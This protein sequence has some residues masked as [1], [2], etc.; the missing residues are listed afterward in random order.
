MCLPLAA[1]AQKTGQNTRKLIPYD[2]YIDDMPNGLRL[3]TVPTDYPHLVAL[4]IV[5]QTGSRNE[6]E[7]GKSGY[8]H[9]F[10]HLMFRGSKNFTPQ[11]RDEILKRAGASSNANTSDDRTIYHEVFSREDLD[12]VMQ[13]EADRFKDLQYDEA[14]F[15]TEALAILGEYNKSIS[16]PL[17]KLEE[18]VR[19]KA[20]DTH[21]YTHTTLGFLKDIQDMPN[22]YKYSLDFYRR[23]YRP[24]YTTILLVGDVSREQAVSLTQKYFADW[25]QGNYK[26][27][28]PA[29]A[30]KSSARTEHVEWPS[31]TLPYVWVAFNGPAYSDSSKDKPALDLLASIA[32]GENSELYHKLVLNEQKVEMLTPYFDNHIDP[33]LFSV[34]ARVKNPADTDYVR[35]QILATFKRFTTEAVPQQRLDSTRSRLRYATALTL[36]SSE[37]LARFL[38]EYVALTRTPDTVNKLYALYDS[39]TPADIRAAAAKYF[40]DNGRTIVT[41]SHNSSA[42]GGQE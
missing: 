14:S 8:A 28:I 37:A 33:E 38:A 19:D 31:E 32:F 3:V 25:K 27:E 9:F 21:T 40:V 1:L 30:Q 7:P 34:I 6:V 12:R 18:V 39:L 11:Q 23:Y 22:Q 17:T 29:E 42:K 26:P 15:K 24:E 16:N 4:Y 36:D 13:L 10:E 41:L 5:V 2:F 20:F 35:D